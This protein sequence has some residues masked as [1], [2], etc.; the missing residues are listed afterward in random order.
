MLLIFMTTT[1]MFQ[2]TKLQ[3]IKKFRSLCST[4]NFTFDQK[5]HKN[6]HVNLTKKT[7]NS[8]S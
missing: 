7:N 8:R 5:D 2:K 1:K 4:G 3:K 6:S